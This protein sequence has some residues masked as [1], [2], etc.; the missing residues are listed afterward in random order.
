MR[1]L[2]GVSWALLPSLL[3]AAFYSLQSLPR[4]LG[5]YFL[6]FFFSSDSFFFY[7]TRPSRSLVA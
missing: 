2:G 6:F 5:V 7:V 3:P 1:L 4:R